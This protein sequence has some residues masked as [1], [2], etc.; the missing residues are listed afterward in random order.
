MRSDSGRT[1]S[2]WMDTAEVPQFPALMEDA[3]AD[4]CVIGAGIAGMMTAYYLVREGRTVIVIDDGPI[5]GGETGRTTAHLS[6]AFDDRYVELEKMHGSAAARLTAESHT[7]AIDALEEVVKTESIDCDFRRLDGWLFLSEGDRKD[8]PT[9]LDEEFEAAKRAGIPVTLEKSAPIPGKN[10]GWALR[11]PRQAQFHPVKFLAGVARAIVARGGRIYT[12]THADS[13]EGGDKPRVKPAGGQTIRCKAIC[14]CTNSPISD[15]VITHLKQAPYRT[16]VIGAEIAADAVQPG[17]YW[18]TP[19]PYHYVRLMKGNAS[20]GDD[21][22]IVGG[23]DH[24][25]GQED[26]AEA[27]FLCLEEWMRERFPEARAVVYR[28]SGQVMEPADYLAFIGRNPDDTPNV[29]IATGDSGNGMTHGAIAGML[30]TDLVLGRANSWAELYDPKRVSVRSAGDILKENLNVA[31]QYADWVK[32]GETD[33]V[34][35]I[36]PGEGAVLRRGVHRIAAYRDDDGTVHER[37]AVC[38]HLACIVRWNGGEKTWDCPCHGSRFD[39]FGNVVNGP[40]I[41]SLG[42]AAEEDHH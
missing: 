42:P 40:A 9:L 20:S 5:A 23:E 28:W 41:K 27:R 4:V 12:K 15:Y 35:N 7:A 22:L 1:Q 31:A 39:A 17:L 8:R 11:F 13:V 33:D 34:A 30:L 25:T 29:Y 18:D 19:S 37:S 32:P 24:K 6:N 2:A 16:F 14:V 21:V 26:D 3:T 10:V 38:T 36:P